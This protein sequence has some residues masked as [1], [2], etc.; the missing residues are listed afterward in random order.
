MFWGIHVK[1]NLIMSTTG[2]DRVGAIKEDSVYMSFELD[3]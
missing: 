2:R 3:C 1:Y